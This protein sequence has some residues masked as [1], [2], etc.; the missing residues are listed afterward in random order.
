MI[1]NFQGVHRHQA[2]GI[3]CSQVPWK[4][5]TQGQAK[6]SYKRVTNI[7]NLSLMNLIP[8]NEN[9]SL[10]ISK[11]LSSKI[12]KNPN[13]SSLKSFVDSNSRNRLRPRSSISSSNSSIDAYKQLAIKHIRNYVDSEDDDFTNR[14]RI[15]STLH[16]GNNELELIDESRCTYA[17]S[18]N[19]SVV[20]RPFFKTVKRKFVVKKVIRPTYSL[21]KININYKEK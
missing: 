21:S 5:L 9:F 20:V 2:Y 16:H 8:T 17:S 19:V 4:A 15:N 14:T 7:Q 11:K 13:F 6:K 10:K 18:L 1:E 3:I 12:T